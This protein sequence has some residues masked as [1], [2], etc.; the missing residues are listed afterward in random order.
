MTMKK[1]K[2]VEISVKAVFSGR[3]S[4]EQVF[5]ELVQKKMELHGKNLDKT[6]AK[7]YT[8]DKVFPDVHAN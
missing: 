7:A 4:P 6:P 8:N 5:I 1:E 2:S 3:K